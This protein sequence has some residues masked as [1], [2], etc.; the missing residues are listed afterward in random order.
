MRGAAIILAGWLAAGAAGAQGGGH[1]MHDYM[2]LYS[3]QGSFEDVR[4]DL[5]LAITGRG[6]K[7]NN[8]AYI[9]RM[10][11]RT[12][13]EVGATRQVFVEAQAFEF[14]SATVSRATMEANPHNIVFCPYVIAV[15]VLP[16]E[17]DRV[18]IAYRRPELVGDAASRR[19]LAA[20]DKLLADIVAEVV[21]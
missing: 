17:P 9:G 12:A 18:Y 7:I 2:R 13:K 16:E 14:C 11:A 19:A 5:E 6:I 21:Q 3:V 4:D 15:Y 8:I 1:G 10:L 20:V